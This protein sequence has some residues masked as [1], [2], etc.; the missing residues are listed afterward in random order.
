LKIKVIANY[1]EESGLVCEKLDDQT[2]FWCEVNHIT[3]N[4]RKMSAHDFMKLIMLSVDDSREEKHKF[5]SMFDKLVGENKYSKRIRLLRLFCNLMALYD[6]FTPEDKNQIDLQFRK[7]NEHLYN[8]QP[9]DPERLSELFDNEENK[10][11]SKRALNLSAVGNKPSSNN[12]YAGHLRL[13]VKSS[14]PR[15]KGNLPNHSH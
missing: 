5:L 10:P 3:D 13:F 9:A 1:L 11:K 4:L 14:M 15:I 8:L 6:K 7:L 2:T 12:P